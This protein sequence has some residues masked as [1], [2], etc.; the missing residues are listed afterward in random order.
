[1]REYSTCKSNEE[2]LFNAMLRSACNPIASA[3]GRLKARWQVL[4][5]KIDFKLEKI[6]TIINACF[7]LHD[8]CE[9]HGVYIN[10][11]QVKTQLELLKTN[12][13]QF[14]ISLTQFF[15]SLRVREKVFGRH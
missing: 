15:P 2:V 7:V 5:K 6:P 4:T 11:E 13:T 12:K 14:K 1:M 8:F 9:R 3:S 10:D